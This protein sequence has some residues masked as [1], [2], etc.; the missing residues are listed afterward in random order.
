[1]DP[2]EGESLEAP[3]EGF[4]ESPRSSGVCW[5]CNLLCRKSTSLQERVNTAVAS[6][7]TVYLPAGEAFLACHTLVGSL[8]RI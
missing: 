1:M 8:F 2:F 3:I 4:D 5:L 6:H 7:E